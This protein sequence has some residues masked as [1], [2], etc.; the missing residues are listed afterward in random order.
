M[1]AVTSPLAG[2]FA[3]AVHTAGYLAVTGLIA[4][5]V[6]RKVGLAVLRKAWFNVDTLW[7]VALVGT[8]VI[9]FLM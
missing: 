1:A 6:Y 2:L 3:T 9:T 7:A 8:G 4:W 5:I